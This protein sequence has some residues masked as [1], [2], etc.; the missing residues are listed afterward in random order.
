MLSQ[1]RRLAWSF[2]LLAAL[3]AAFASGAFAVTAGRSHTAHAVKHA[4]R[5][6]ARIK[7]RRSHTKARRSHTKAHRSYTKAHRTH[8]KARRSRGSHGRR[9]DARKTR[10]STRKTR[11]STRPGTRATLCASASRHRR[12]RR[13]KAACNHRTPPAVTSAP[14]VSGSAAVGQTLSV[15]DGSWS[16]TQPIAYAIQ[17]QR[18]G[19]NIAGATGPAYKL[20]AGDAG[21]RI[22]VAVTASNPL[23]SNSATSAPTGVVSGKGSGTSPIGQSGGASSVIGAAPTGPAAPAGGWSVAF[24]DGFNA[25]LGTGPGQDNFWYPNRFC[26]S[27]GS[28]AKGFNSTELEVF[29]SS[30]VQVGS[31]G[32]ELVDTYQ[33]NTGGTGKNYVS[34]TVNTDLPSAPGYN[35]FKWTPG[36]GEKW[37]FECVCRLPRNTGE[38]DPGWWS[39]DYPWN[40]ELDFFEFWG[41]NTWAKYNMGVAWI[42]KTPSSLTESEHD[43]GEDF[44]PSAA[45]HRYTTVINPNNTVE[46]F[47]DGVRQSWV[48]NNGV[49]GPVS[50][51]VVAMGLKLSNG[52]RGSG[53]NFTSGSRT[54]SIRSIAVY[55]DAGHA[56]Q[57]VSGGGIAPGTTVE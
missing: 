22:D 30:Q 27:P 12:H 40:D 20:V 55:E 57:A 17:W 54:F 21:H 42:Y 36:Q 5:A 53:A 56:G 11:S 2:A 32:L 6:G 18:E 10:S 8:A 1:V 50:P 47:I 38:E 7:A 4:R 16:G 14:T 3:A 29:N 41:W 13:G 37:A 35:L 34:G 19:A 15:S 28:D 33:P 9:H 26:C 51:A 52:L 46:E 31:E 48:G 24:A 49:L 45:F 39:S 44:D 25:P 23:G 43:L